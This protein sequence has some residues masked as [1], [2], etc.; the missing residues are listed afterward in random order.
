M[1]AEES[2]P[3]PRSFQRST[4][5]A[6]NDADGVPAFPRRRRAFHGR[7]LRFPAQWVVGNDDA[8]PTKYRTNHLNGIHGLGLA[9]LCL[10]SVDASDVIGSDL[11]QQ[12]VGD[13]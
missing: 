10:R 8:V 11:R 4:S 12:L 13:G 5:L 1:R 2:A 6:G 3:E 9:T 7:G